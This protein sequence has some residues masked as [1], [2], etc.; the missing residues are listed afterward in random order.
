M[1][2]AVF[3]MVTEH[4]FYVTEVLL[5]HSNTLL[6]NNSIV[7]LEEITG[8]SDLFCLTNTTACC[9]HIHTRSGPAGNWYFPNGTEVPNDNS[10]F[11]VDRGNSSVALTYSGMASPTTTGLYRCTIPTAPNN[12][13]VT[14]IAGIYGNMKGKPN[15]SL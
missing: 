13:S 3:D 9:R 6:S 14:L 1:K 4:V 15:C 8:G 2:N 5:K 12:R 7:D 10:R 11:S